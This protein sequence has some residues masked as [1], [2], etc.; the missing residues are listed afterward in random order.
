VKR[1]CRRPPASLHLLMLAAL[2]A[3]AAFAPARTAHAFDIATGVDDLKLRWDTTV[4]YT[5]A[6]RVR[7]QSPLLI[8]GA[9]YDDGDRNF[10]RGL[11]NNRLDLLSEADL[12]YGAFGG[13]ISGAGWYDS[14]YRQDGDHDS[15]ATSNTTSTAFP[16]FP[17]GTR[18]LHGKKGELLDAFVYGRFDLGDEARLNFRAGRHTLQWGESLFFGS[19]AIAGGMAPVDVIKAL[20]VPNT[21]FKEL[22]RPVGQVS[23]Q[24]QLASNL[25]VGA[26]VQYKWEPH[27]LPGA[28]SYF[29][30]SDA[31]PGTGELLLL[32]PGLAIP[33]TPEVRA[34][35]SGQGGLQLRWRPAGLETDLGFYA[36]RYHDKAPQLYMH[37]AA[38]APGVVVPTD[39]YFVYPEGINAYGVSATHTVGD[40]NL[41]AEV[42]VRK[43]AP[44]SST[45]AV[46]IPALGVASQPARGTTWHAN[47]SWLASLG[48]SF[49]AQE[50]S[51][52]GEIAANYTEKVT[53]GEDHLDP[54]SRRSGLGL[55]LSYEPTYRQALNGLD[56]GVP[57]GIGYAPAGKSSAGGGLGAHHGGDMSIGLNL[58]YLDV[59]RM[60]LAYTHYYGPEGLF[61][62]AANH[63][64]F[65]N[66]TRDRD[67]VALSIRRTF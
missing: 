61:L 13:R 12:S 28:G 42:S 44:L 62:D 54:N 45:A 38:V 29:S 50:A 46:Q 55:R 24:L 53:Q 31:A 60:S 52:V 16:G 58:T 67:F 3:T 59:W 34:K 10:K 22:L 20:S 27:R 66:T 47:F 26:Y 40:Y 57:V 65:L 56:V 9:N 39:Y 8:G 49:V 6:A 7:E 23:G 15:P 32:G 25:A 1:P 2:A 48:P 18:K 4:K 35:N 19:N 5:A 36:I 21:Q 11:I 43:N 30:S 51:F 14:V 41:A 17:E 37:A 64:T 63:Q 33:Q